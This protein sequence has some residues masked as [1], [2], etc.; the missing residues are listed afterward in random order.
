M[1]FDDLFERLYPSLH[2][3]CFRLTGDEDEADDVAQEAFVRMVRHDVTGEI[4]GVRSWLFRTALNLVRDRS[5]VRSNRER[6]LEANPAHSAAPDD[7]E[8]P[9]R[10][11][12]RAENVRRVRRVLATLDER[13]RALLLMRE[14]G[15]RYREIAEAVGVATSSVGTLLS[16]AQTRFAQ[17]YREADAGPDDASTRIRG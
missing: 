15:F 7:P 9:D 13:D 3:Y 8:T 1:D 4:P 17:A 14:E 12:E 16:R 6:L 11:S 5:R 2:R 10:A